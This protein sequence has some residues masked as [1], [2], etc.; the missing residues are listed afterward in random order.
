MGTP[1]SQSPWGPL[2]VFKG[3]AASALLKPPL[4]VQPRQEQVAKRRTSVQAPAPAQS[5]EPSRIYSI[6][7]LPIAV[8]SPH[9][10][11]VAYEHSFHFFLFNSFHAHPHERLRA[12]MQTPR[13]Q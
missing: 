5:G 6:P 2:K 4:S 1:A 11:V 12:S 3:Y 13:D 10:F 7:P 9:E 8:K